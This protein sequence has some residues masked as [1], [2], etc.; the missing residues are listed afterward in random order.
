MSKPLLTEI[1]LNS[2]GGAASRN[3]FIIVRV[4]PERRNIVMGTASLYDQ[5]LGSTYTYEL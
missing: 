3:S 1:E 5:H 2:V 4:T